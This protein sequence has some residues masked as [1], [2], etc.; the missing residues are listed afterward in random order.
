MAFEG[1]DAPLAKVELAFK[2]RNGKEWEQWTVREFWMKERLG[3]PYHGLVDVVT[4]RRNVDFSAL[5]AKSCVL[6]LRRGPDRV[7]RFHGLVF[8]VEHLGAHAG[9]ALARVSVA[10]AVHALSYG[11][12]SRFFE[13]ATAAEIIEKVL[14]AGLEPFGRKVRL[15]LVRKYAKREYTTQDR[16]DDLSFVH[17]LMVDEGITFHFEQSMEVETLVVVDSNYSLPRI[18]TMKEPEPRAIPAPVLVQPRDRDRYVRLKLRAGLGAPRAS[19][20]YVLTLDDGSQREGKTSGDGL[21]IERV[22]PSL[23]QATV[24]IEGPLGIEEYVLRFGS[25]D[26]VSR[27]SGIHQ[28]LRHGGW[29]G[30]EG[31]QSEEE[32]RGAVACFQE[33]QGLEP[34][35]EL[36]DATRKRLKEVHGS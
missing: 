25:L 10:A 26:A 16:E 30:G 32:I 29:L 1:D 19:K 8:K 13:D 9:S 4:D 35:G 34:T 17:R 24:R 23:R 12:N 15:N 21:I 7:R 20:E 31:G 14:K 33:Q 3:S 18:K 22:P 27:L 28:R 2:T 36:D 11:Q 5:L 6:E